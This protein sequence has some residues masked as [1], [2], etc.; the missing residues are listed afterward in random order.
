MPGRSLGVRLDPRL[1]KPNALVLAISAAFAFVLL[2]PVTA[3]A[4][5]PDGPKASRPSIANV[6]PAAGRIQ[7]TL[8]PSLGPHHSAA[9]HQAPPFH[10]KNPAALRAAKLKANAASR[11]SAA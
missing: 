2:A 6:V 5:R 7:A 10:T 4:A 3:G 11:H 8:L 1:P 9:A